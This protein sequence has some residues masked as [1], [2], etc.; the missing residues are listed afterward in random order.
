MVLERQKDR[1]LGPPWL[2]SIRQAELLNHYIATSALCERPQDFGAS[3]SAE[4]AQEAV[5]R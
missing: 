3:D 4:A 1:R 2:G 5:E